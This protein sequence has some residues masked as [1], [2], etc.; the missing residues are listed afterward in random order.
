MQTQFH[1]TRPARLLKLMFAKLDMNEGHAA[2][3]W[4]RRAIGVII[5]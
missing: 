1:Y 3:Y 5:R 4:A 2:F